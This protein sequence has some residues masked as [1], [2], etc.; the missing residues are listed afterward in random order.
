MHWPA[1]IQEARV[2]HKT[3]SSMDIFPTLLEITGITVPQ[4]RP[5][6]GTS[7]SPLL[8]DSQNNAHNELKD[9]II[10]FLC[11]D[12]L[13]AARYK[14]YK[15]HFRTFKVL[16]DTDYSELCYNGIAYDDYYHSSCECHSSQKLNSPLVY[17]VDQDPRELYPLSKDIANDLLEEIQDEVTE[18]MKTLTPP[19]EKLLERTNCVISL[20]PC[21]NPPYCICK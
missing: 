9:R 10:V 17:N 4:D 19:E 5:I 1:V 2:I 13:M 3:I 8:F 14:K 21:C 12:V 7:F 18:Y 15:I 20:N 16:N 6:D 11:E